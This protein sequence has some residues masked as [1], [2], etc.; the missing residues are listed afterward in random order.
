LR[1]RACETNIDLVETKETLDTGL[2][3]LSWPEGGGEQ[4]CSGY[5]P[6]AKR[7]LEAALVR[8]LGA[9]EFATIA[10]AW[11]AADHAAV[12]RAWREDCK[13]WNFWVNGHQSLYDAFV[14]EPTARLLDGLEAGRHCGTALGL[15]TSFVAVDAR[16]FVAAWNR[17]ANCENPEVA[18]FGPLLTHP[19]DAWA[20]GLAVGSLL[21]GDGDPTPTAF[22][23]VLRA[24]DLAIGA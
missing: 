18:A 20:V 2:S 19:P 15:P 13:K 16:A 11:R 12:V 10:A 6:G 4:R 1:H 21:I 17:V 7:F 14:H 3:G 23:P 5:S 8:T 9:R 22:E 24:V